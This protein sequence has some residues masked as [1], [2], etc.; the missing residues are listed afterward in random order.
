MSQLSY[1]ALVD[2]DQPQAA[3][4]NTR[5]LLSINLINN[6]LESD[7]LANSCV[8]TSKISSG[9]VTGPKIAMG[10]DALGDMLYHNG[11]NYAR[12]AGNTSSTAKILTQTGTGSVSAA[13]VWGDL[14]VS[15]RGQFLNLKAITGADSSQW[16]VTAD[17]LVLHST[18]SVAALVTSFNK[19]LDLDS[20][21]AGGVSTGAKAANTIYHV[22]AIRKSSDGTTNLVAAITSKTLSDVLT[23]VGSSYDQAAIVS[24]IGTN[25]SSAIIPAIQYGRTYSFSAWATL[26]SAN[27]GNTW[28]ALDLTPSNM[29]T[30]PGFVPNTLSTLCFG[31]IGTTSNTSAQISNDSAVATGTT[32]AP[33]K[34]SVI[35]P[36]GV[37]ACN[38]WRFD[39]LTSDTIYYLNDGSGTA[40][41]YLQGFELNK[42]G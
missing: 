37:S 38:M 28:T 36:A 33:N 21:G 11:T 2:G 4:F 19:T 13:P 17:Q 23:D 10:S 25:N 16:T 35:A 20:S 15:S 40:T 30:V 41:V 26:A 12:I 29:T 6:G 32:V 22:W 14:G 39:V 8:T 7:N 3:G 5:F 1:T 31:S 18:S 42:L 27:P 9:A 24:V 34:L